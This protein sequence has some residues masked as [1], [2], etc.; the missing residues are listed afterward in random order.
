MA[1]PFR[2]ATIHVITPITGMI[3]ELQDAPTLVQVANVLLDYVVM[4]VII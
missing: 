4:G 2:E 3:V 1:V